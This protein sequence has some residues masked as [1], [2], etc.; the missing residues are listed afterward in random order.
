MSNIEQNTL[1]A[2]QSIILQ[3]AD[4]LEVG[5]Q[6]RIHRGYEYIKQTFAQCQVDEAGKVC[7]GFCAI[8]VANLGRYGGVPTGVW[9]E[10][11]EELLEGYFGAI[12]LVK[13]LQASYGLCVVHPVKGDY[14][15]LTET[16][17]SLDDFHDWTV[18]EIIDWLRALRYREERGCWQ[19]PREEGEE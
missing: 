10:E 4:W 18:P 13:G 17:A 2:Q 16:M 6:I 19:A 1:A 9:A 7:Y 12:A 15:T 11:D 5:E 3:I 8:G 14:H